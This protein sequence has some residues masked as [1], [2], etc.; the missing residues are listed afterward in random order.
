MW[1]F[2]RETSSSTGGVKDCWALRVRQQLVNSDQSNPKQKAGGLGKKVAYKTSHPWT[3]FKKTKQE[4]FGVFI[5]GTLQVPWYICF[6][7]L[8][9]H[10][11]GLWWPLLSDPCAGAG[12]AHGYQHG[13]LCL[14]FVEEHPVV[15]EACA[16]HC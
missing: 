16:W 6:V 9:R 2:Q 10:E 5:Q 12:P 14:G 4:K 3:L 8:R 7:F 1:D 11:V 15:S 13:I